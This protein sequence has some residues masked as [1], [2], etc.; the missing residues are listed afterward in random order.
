MRSPGEQKHP[1]SVHD[2]GDDTGRYDDIGPGLGCPEGSI[3]V[4]LHLTERSGSSGT[5][6]AA[7]GGPTQMAPDPSAQPKVKGG[8]GGNSAAHTAHTRDSP[9]EKMFN[10]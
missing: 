3:E 2:I 6:A 10:S 5:A 1:K 4:F 8:L 9:E 7:A